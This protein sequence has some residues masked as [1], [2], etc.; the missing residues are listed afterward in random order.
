V[1]RLADDHALARDLAGWLAEIPGIGV[2]VEAVQT[3]IVLFDLPAPHRAP[4]VLARLA[5][6]GV[7]FDEVG[8][9][10]LR[11][12]THLDIGRDEARRAVNAL[13]EVLTGP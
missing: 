3:N 6:H 13:R 11:A 8:P 2:E 9:Q 1:D 10:R 4:S 7:R 12:V 5:A